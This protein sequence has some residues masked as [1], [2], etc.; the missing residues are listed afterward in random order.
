[1]RFAFAGEVPIFLSN[2]R[3]TREVLLRLRWLF[4][5]F[6]R[7][8]LPPA[9]TWNRRF[10]P[11]WVLIFGIFGYLVLSVDPLAPEFA[12]TATSSGARIMLSERAS[13]MGARS[14]LAPS[15]RFSAARRKSFMANSG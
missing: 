5:P 1:M 2:A 11:L 13:I 7:T 10:A 12:A 4:G 14:S 15:A 6:V 8:T 9:V 3:R